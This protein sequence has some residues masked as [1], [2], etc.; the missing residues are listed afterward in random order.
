MIGIDCACD[1]YNLAG[2]GSCVRL[3]HRSLKNGSLWA[4]LIGLVAI[5]LSPVSS[6]RK[7]TLL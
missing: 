7:S 2:V 3:R 1:R 4:A 5:T 6:I